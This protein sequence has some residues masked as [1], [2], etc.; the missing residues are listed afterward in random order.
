MRASAG[1]KRELDPAVRIVGIRVDEDDRL[2]GTEL[3][4]PGRHGQHQRRTEEHR[5]EVI[6]AVP[7]GT[8]PVPVAVVTGEQACQ[9]FGEVALGRRLDLHEG[10]TGGGMRSQDVAEAVSARRAEPD[11][12]A[13]DV[14]HLAIAGRDVDLFGLQDLPSRDGP[15]RSASAGRKPW[16]VTGWPVSAP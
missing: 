10:Q 7:K 1:Q 11:D 15:A 14:D 9:Q 8:V 13:R 16:V 6:G 4:S 2:P 3:E 12:V 5:Q